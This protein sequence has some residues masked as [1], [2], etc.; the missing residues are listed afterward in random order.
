MHVH[1]SFVERPVDPWHALWLC[2]LASF[3]EAVEQGGA[4]IPTRD[5]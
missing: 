5:T 1:V 3:L 2:A 4:Q